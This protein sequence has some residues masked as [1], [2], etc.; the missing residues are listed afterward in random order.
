[1]RHPHRSGK[2]YAKQPFTRTRS[3]STSAPPRCTPPAA[4]DRILRLTPKLSPPAFSAP[5]TPAPSTTSPP[6]ATTHARFVYVWY[7][8]EYSY[9]LPGDPRDGPPRRDESACVAHHEPRP[10]ACLKP[11]CGC[12]G[13]RRCAAAEK[14]REQ[15]V[16]KWSTGIRQVVSC[17]DNRQ[18]RPDDTSGRL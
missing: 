9:R 12:P 8:N 3:T 11:V 14:Q 16:G 15:P 2:A 7:D 17:R 13:G 18:S 6:S 4:P 10:D 1:V 5:A